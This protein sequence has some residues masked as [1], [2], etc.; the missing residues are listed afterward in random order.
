MTRVG[1][2]ETA[3]VAEDTVDTGQERLEEKNL[4]NLEK[5]DL[6]VHNKTQVG[7][8]DRNTDFV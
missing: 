1:N 6:E 8:M 2:P 5:L 7:N 3:Q 4:R